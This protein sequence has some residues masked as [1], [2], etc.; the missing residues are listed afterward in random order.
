VKVKA[1]VR[2]QIKALR[3]D[4]LVICLLIAATY[5]AGTI[6]A[7]VSPSSLD[8]GVTTVGGTEAIAVIFVFIAGIASFRSN[9]LLLMQNG[10]GRRQIIKSQIAAAAGVS[11]ILA[12][13]TAIFNEMGTWISS[14]L[15]NFN[16]TNTTLEVYQESLGDSGLIIR[17]VFT[18][19]LLFMMYL[20]TYAFGYV[21]GVLGYRGGTPAIVGMSVGLPVILFILLPIWISFLS[22]GMQDKLLSFF[23]NTLLGAGMRQPWRGGLTF[24]AAALILGAFGAWLA[25][26]AQ[27]K[28]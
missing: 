16:F 12:V 2:Y 4:V 8:E 10:L 7:V 20:A 6:W 9:F 17:F 3:S 18:L 23:L 25:G 5:A 28:E 13:V 1:A 21:L 14:H 27:V 22:K 24:L 11:L 15:N 26:R 19:C